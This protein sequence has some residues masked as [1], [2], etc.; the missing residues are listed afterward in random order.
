MS[1]ENNTTS[2]FGFDD[3]KKRVNQ[4][5]IRTQFRS[6][7]IGGFNQEDVSNY[8]TYLE[9]K[10]RKLEQAENERNKDYLLLKEK[11]TA[12]TEA[13]KSL[14]E[15]LEKAQAGFDQYAAECKEKDIQLHALQEQDHSETDQMKN[16]MQQISVERDQLKAE[17]TQSAEKLQALTEKTSGFETKHTDLQLKIDRLENEISSHNQKYDEVTKT[18][19]EYEQK[20]QLEKSHN[21]QQS[22]EMGA[23]MQKIVSLEK[24]IAEKSEE[25]DTERKNSEKVE[26]ELKQEKLRASNF[27]VSKFKEEI[28]GIYKVVENM[29]KEQQEITNDL[30]QQLED[31]KSRANDAEE[32][33]LSMSKWITKVKDNFYSEQSVLEEQLKHVIE[34]RDKMKGEFEERLEELQKFESKSDAQNAGCPLRLII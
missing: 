17:L 32:T 19:L 12:E 7:V 9:E 11:L 10:F 4:D 15:N 27:E 21:E 3:L 23:L 26:Q 2:T 24:M 31:E 5:S 13:K 6:Q 29:K 20:L 1:N 18:L 30:K 33:L 34:N 8:I 22:L 16:E 28:A 25:L 14:Q